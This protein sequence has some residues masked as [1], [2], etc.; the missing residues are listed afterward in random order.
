[1]KEITLI[2]FAALAATGCTALQNRRLHHGSFGGSRRAQR[3][4]NRYLKKPISWRIFIHSRLHDIGRRIEKCG[5]S[6][7]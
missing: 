4:S 3:F 7:C 6:A 2:I 1:M 5:E